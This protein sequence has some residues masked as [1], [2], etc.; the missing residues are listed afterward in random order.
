LLSADM[1][2]WRGPWPCLI[3]TVGGVLALSLPVLASS[4]NWKIWS[5][6]RCGTNTQRLVLSVM[7]ACAFLAVGITWCGSATLPSLP[8][9]LTLTRLA[10]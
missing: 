5:V 7:M 1:M 8:I 2:M 10:P 3:C 6:P 4:L 9:A